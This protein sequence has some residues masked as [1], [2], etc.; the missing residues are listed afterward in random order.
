MIVCDIVKVLPYNTFELKSSNKTFRVMLEFY[1][2]GN[3]KVGDKILIHEK[4][5]DVNWSGY[6]QPYAFELNQT[7]LPKQ[8]MLNNDAEFVV[9]GSGSKNF[10]LKRIYG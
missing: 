10:V 8:V 4:L 7:M 5:V 3:P 9:L 6:T 1:N 2:I